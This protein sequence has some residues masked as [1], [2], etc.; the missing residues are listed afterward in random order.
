MGN[1]TFSARDYATYTT[2]ASA[3]KAAK[4]VTE[5]FTA[6]NIDAYLDPSKFMVRESRHSDANPRSTPIILGLDI[7]GSM[8]H[9]AKE[10]AQ[11]GFGILIKEILDRK[12]VSDP[13]IMFSAIGDVDWDEVV[14]QA[15]QFE[16]DIKI[17]DQLTKLCLT[18]SGGGGNWWE[19]YNA[20]WHMAA[21]HTSCDAF[22]KDGRK[23]F[24]FTFGDEEVPSDLNATRLKKIYKRDDE[25]VASNTQLLEL[26]EEKYHVFHIIIEQGNHMRYH[27]KEVIK[28]WQELLGQNALMCSDYKKLS[29]IIVSAMQVM[30]GNDAAD[31]AKSWSGDTSLVVA[32]AV[33][34]LIAKKDIDGGSAMV[35]L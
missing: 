1:S 12:P 26:L 32:K 23:G 21:F 22:E 2:R 3:Y 14:L 10:I 5:V 25:I 18:R 24:L 28:Q 20:L 30:A 9:I 19:S 31:V 15:S 33:G 4:S 34:N 11:E 17:V 8:G 27:P 35:R 16:A 7:T 13:H 29:E 6:S